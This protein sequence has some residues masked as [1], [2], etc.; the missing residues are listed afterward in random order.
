MHA[1]GVWTEL[2]DE[3]LFGQARVA[4]DGTVLEWPQPVRAN[5]EAMVHI[6]ADGLW[7]MAVEQSVQPKA[8]LEAVRE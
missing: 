4:F 8:S 2:R 5:G 3:R 7:A 1:G 6:D